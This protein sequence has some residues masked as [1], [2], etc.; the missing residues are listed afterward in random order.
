MG[1]TLDERKPDGLASPPPLGREDSEFGLLKSKRDRPNHLHRPPLSPPHVRGIGWWTVD[2]AG[3]LIGEPVT[4][5]VAVT[6][7]HI[8]AEPAFEVVP[9]GI[10]V[11]HI[12]AIILPFPVSLDDVIDGTATHFFH[13]AFRPQ[14]GSLEL[15]VSEASDLI[16][17]LG[18]DV[19][20][21]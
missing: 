10:G 3:D 4:H 14:P 9:A 5:R 15:L 1:L 21:N 19:S 18:P 7:E 6:K 12:T 17:C 20:L 16:T 2:P 8:V 11:G 13:G